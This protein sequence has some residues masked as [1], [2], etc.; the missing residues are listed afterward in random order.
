MNSIGVST[1]WVVPLRHGV[2]SLS[3]TL[4]WRLMRSRP[5]AIAGRVM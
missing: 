2:F 1:M 4:P 3:T 5:L